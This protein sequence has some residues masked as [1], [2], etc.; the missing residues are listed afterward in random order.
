MKRRP[1]Q[2]P[3]GHAGNLRSRNRQGVPGPLCRQTVPL[4]RSNELTLNGRQTASVNHPIM[5]LRQLD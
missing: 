4:R 1:R 5:G 3:F 2:R